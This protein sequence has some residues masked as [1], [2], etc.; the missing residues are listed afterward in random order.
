MNHKKELLWSLWVETLTV[1]VIL[2]LSR[3]GGVEHKLEV[4]GSARAESISLPVQILGRGQSTTSTR[5]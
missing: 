3:S 4:L 5:S 1:T 2:Q